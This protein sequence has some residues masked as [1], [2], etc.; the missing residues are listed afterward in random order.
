MR[1]LFCTFC[2]CAF[3]S[4]SVVFGQGQNVTLSIPNDYCVTS[5]PQV[6]TSIDYNVTLHLTECI[7]MFGATAGSTASNLQ[8]GNNPMGQGQSSSVAIALLKSV[9]TSGTGSSYN[10]GLDC[11]EDGADDAN[12]IV[13]FENA[14]AS[15]DELASASTNFTFDIGGDV[16]RARDNAP[17][18]GPANQSYLMVQAGASNT[19]TISIAEDS[20]QGQ[21]FVLIFDAQSGAAIATLNPKSPDQS[22][23]ADKTV[24][25][26]PIIKPKNGR[27]DGKSTITWE[28]GD[29]KKNGKVIVE[30]EG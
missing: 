24:Y 20:R 4:L 18:E 7:N 3:V 27:E 17:V 5:S 10:F 6:G 26:M 30:E 1:N 2:C 22:F 8:M 28:V 11:G 16:M 19:A 14:T 25:V 13:N 15:L 12:V 29:P 21:C 9:S 23:V